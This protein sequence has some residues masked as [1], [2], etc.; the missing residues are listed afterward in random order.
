MEYCTRDMPIDR[1]FVSLHS[2]ASHADAVVPNGR[3]E[4]SRMKEA[5]VC[6]FGSLATNSAAQIPERELLCA[7]SAVLRIPAWEI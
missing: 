5:D 2:I 3:I 4:I 7:T 1:T 6:L